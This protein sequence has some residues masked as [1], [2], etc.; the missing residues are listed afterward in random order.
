MVRFL[1]FNLLKILL[2]LVHLCLHSHHRSSSSF[3]HSRW[4]ARKIRGRDG[5][6]GARAARRAASGRSLRRERAV[7]AA[8]EVAVAARRPASSA[9]RAKQP[10]GRDGATTAAAPVAGSL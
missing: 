6:A 9:Q 8:G 2:L 10:A 1:L 7:M 4:K 3:L 5:P